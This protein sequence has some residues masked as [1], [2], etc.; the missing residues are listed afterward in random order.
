[1]LWRF[2]S[3]SLPTL[4][5]HICLAPLKITSSPA[6]P[7]HLIPLLEDFVQKYQ[8]PALTDAGFQVLRLEHIFSQL[9]FSLP[10]PS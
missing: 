10:K 2:F 6:R 3:D 9:R 1:M 4:C 7:K 8:L 5:R